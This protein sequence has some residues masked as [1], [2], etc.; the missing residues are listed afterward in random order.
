MTASRGASRT[1]LIRLVAGREI[2]VKI[3]DKGFLA[4]TLVFVAVIVIAIVVPTLIEGDTPEYTVASTADARPVAE[5][6]AAIGADGGLGLPE[7]AIT[8]IDAEDPAAA[9]A[10]PDVDAALSL[11]P[12]GAVVVTAREGVPG[13]LEELVATA[14]AAAS[15]Q[16]VAAEAGLSADQVAALT[17]PTPPRVDLL[18]PKE[19]QPVPPELVVVIFGF[20]FYFTVLTFG[21]AI[22]QSVVEEKSSRVVEILVAAVPIRWLL[23]GKVLGNA[24][25]AL[26]QV[27]L[28]VGA[29]L[30][31][32]RA[33]GQGEIVSQV[34]VV[35]GWFLAFFVLGFLML[36]CLWAVAGSL[37]SR[38]EELQSTT[39]YMQIA[40]MV[41]FFTAIFL[42]T[43]SPARI[44][45]SYF[46]LTAPLLM[47]ARV[48]TGDAAAWEPWV[49]M[50]VVALTALALVAIGA[51]LYAGSVLNTS[52]RTKLGGAWAA[53][54]R[55]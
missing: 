23:A 26:G 33:M 7:A 51:R 34:L 15:A 38:I 43:E 52:S 54:G 40:V 17:T 18:E 30:L 44:A 27:V 37:A 16:A 4:S 12:D 9:V 36:A 3:R 19:E 55:A 53:G 32:A 10:D 47:P 2:A 50:G 20:M 29:G 6:A 41:P 8:V 13:A 45:L 42:Q 14:S 35:S 25:M 31:G 39:L 46:P 22:A 24:V 48:A 1:D 5:T 28:I 11:D 21:V 49:A